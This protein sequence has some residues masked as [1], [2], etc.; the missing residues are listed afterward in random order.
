MAVTAVQ[1]SMLQVSPVGVAIGPD[2]QVYEADVLPSRVRVLT[3]IPI[4]GVSFD[5]SPAPI[6]L[7]AGSTV[8]ATTLNWSAS[9]YSSLQIFAKTEHCPRMSEPA[10]PRQPE[11]G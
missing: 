5:A 10:V 3:P 2:G 8:G 1:P 11:I 7:A 4:P 6:P 9:G